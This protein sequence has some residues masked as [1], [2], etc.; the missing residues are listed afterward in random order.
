MSHYR[1]SQLHVDENYS[2]LFNLRP[3]IYKSWCLNTHVIPKSTDFIANKTNSKRLFSPLAVKGWGVQL[4]PYKRASE[5]NKRIL[6][7]RSQRD[8]RHNN[9]SICPAA[10]LSFL[11]FPWLVFKLRQ[12]PGPGNDVT[13]VNLSVGQ[14][15]TGCYFHGYIPRLGNVYGWVARDA[16]RWLARRRQ[17]P[18]QPSGGVTFLVGYL[19]ISRQ[20]F[21]RFY[22]IALENLKVILPRLSLLK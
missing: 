12:A 10:H 5:V 17:T 14:G 6:R 9:Q 19:L 11:H 16:A 22:M 13:L 8:E 1:N 21:L 20:R 18:G 4:Y 3:N 7:F 15:Y 2:Y